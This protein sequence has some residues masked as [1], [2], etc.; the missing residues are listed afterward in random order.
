MVLA[1]ELGRKRIEAIP[2]NHWTIRLEI[3]D[4]TSTLKTAVGAFP[5]GQPD[6]FIAPIKMKGGKTSYQLF[7]GDYP[8]KAA[9][10]QAAKKVPATFLEGGQRPKPYLGTGIPK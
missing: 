9:A 5:A 2:P 6:L 7:L 1:V 8:S 10:E 3:A 4:L